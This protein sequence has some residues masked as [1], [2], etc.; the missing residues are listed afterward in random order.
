MDGRIAHAAAWFTL[1]RMDEN[2]KGPY[3][4]VTGLPSR[5]ISS[6]GA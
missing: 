4:P 1:E 6:L 3:A 2:I 5:A